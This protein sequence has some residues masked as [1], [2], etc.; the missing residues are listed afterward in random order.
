[1]GLFGSVG[2][3][4]LGAFRYILSSENLQSD[5]PLI[6]SSFTKSG[7]D[8]RLRNN[9]AIGNPIGIIDECI[10]GNGTLD[11]VFNLTINGGFGN[12]QGI[13]NM[14]NQ[15]KNYTEDSPLIDQIDE[16]TSKISSTYEE[17]KEKLLGYNTLMNE[18]FNDI[19]AAVDAL[20]EI[21][22]EGDK[23]VGEL[24]SVF[25]CSKISYIIIFYRIYRSSHGRSSF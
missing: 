7:E 8:V 1:M 9:L 4:A 12:L 16:L 3:D 22:T 20:I 13:Y 15:I 24:L 25:N 11:N 6:I 10:N 19:V 5:N 17:D 14:R 23:I 18:A 2:S 21:Y